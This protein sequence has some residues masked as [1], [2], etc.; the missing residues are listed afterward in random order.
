[1]ILDFFAWSWTTGQALMEVNI[2]DNK[3]HWFYLIQLDEIIRKDT[4]QYKF[5]LENWLNQTVDQLMLHRI[6]KVKKK[7]WIEIDFNIIN[8]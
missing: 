3:K 2:E 4:E 1:M 8:Q 5:A 7:L 6:D